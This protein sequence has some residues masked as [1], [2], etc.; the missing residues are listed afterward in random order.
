MAFLLPVRVEKIRLSGNISR[1]M[2]FNGELHKRFT[3]RSLQT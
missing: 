1:E 3:T 2:T